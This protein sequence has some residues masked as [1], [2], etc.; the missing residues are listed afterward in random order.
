MPP[1]HKRMNTALNFNP[2][3]AEPFA[4]RSNSVKKINSI[5][6]HSRSR[7][8][9]I[10]SRNSKVCSAYSIALGSPLGHKGENKS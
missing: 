5:V 9:E 7:I 6:H 10:H 2:V 1:I 8:D 3:L 4:S